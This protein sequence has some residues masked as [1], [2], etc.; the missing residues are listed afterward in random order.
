M[1]PTLAIRSRLALGTALLLVAI[2]T[3]AIVISGTSTTRASSPSVTPSSAALANFGIF[4]REAVAADA[5][6]ARQASRPVPAGT[7]TRRLPTVYPTYAQWATLEGDRLCV[8]DKYTPVSGP[9]DQGGACNSASYLEKEHQLL[10]S[11]SQTDD[12]TSTPPPPGQANVISGLA[13]D[14]VTSVTLRFADGSQQTVL[15]EDNGFMLNLG[16]SPKTLA[17]VTWTDASGQDHSE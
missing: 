17:K 8:V 5:L 3:S 15:V 6:L 9:S 13:P 10:V 4:R 7:L 14:G 1:M 12:T 2:A 16:S 11:M